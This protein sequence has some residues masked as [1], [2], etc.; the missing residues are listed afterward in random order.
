[1]DE[2]QHEFNPGPEVMRA[3]LSEE[4]INFTRELWAREME[5][6]VLEWL[7][8]DPEA[9]VKAGFVAAIVAQV[10]TEASKLL[11]QN[12]KLTVPQALE[13]VTRSVGAIFGQPAREAH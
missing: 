8:G 6:L 2:L 3:R 7:R 10:W 12:P 9:E 11:R 1:M 13:S 5:E 4:A